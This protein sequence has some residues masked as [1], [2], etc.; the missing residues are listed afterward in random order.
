M[1]DAFLFF[2][3]SPFQIQKKLFGASSSGQ[4][5]VS[6]PAAGRKDTMTGYENGQW[7]SSYS[8]ADCP[9]AF[10][11]QCFRNV[12]IGNG[13]SVRNLQKLLPNLFLKLRAIKGQRQG[14]LLP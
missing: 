4:A 1:T 2:I 10:L 8:G 3:N 5:E 6:N 7:I 13:L 9:G 14:K 12:A 11:S